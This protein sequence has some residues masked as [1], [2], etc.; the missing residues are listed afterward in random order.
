MQYMSTKG[1]VKVIKKGDIKAP[2]KVKVKSR[3][4]AAREMVSTVTNWVS[5]LQVRKGNETRAAIE[6]FF[7]T[8]TRPTEI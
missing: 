8:Q 7:S 5:D 1:K 3:R 2:V 4:A 6:K